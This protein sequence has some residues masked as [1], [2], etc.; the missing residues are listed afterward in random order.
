MGC[1]DDEDDLRCVL[2]VTPA[3]DAVT[4]TWRLAKGSYE[5]VPEPAPHL[6]SDD[7][8]D[9][10]QWRY[11]AVWNGGRYHAWCDSVEDVI[12]VYYY[13]PWLR[14]YLDGEPG[15]DEWWAAVVARLDGLV[16][17]WT[18]E[19]LQQAQEDGVVLPVAEREAIYAARQNP[20][21]GGRWDGAVPLFLLSTDYQPFTSRVAPTGNVVMV[22]ARDEDELLDLLRAHGGLEVTELG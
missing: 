22:D 12:D 4:M 8:E 20:P 19:A 5:H 10:G 15:S 14:S 2:S 3:R 6:G 1:A 16:T 13:D 17:R 9:G 11:Y 21:D 7:A 18:I